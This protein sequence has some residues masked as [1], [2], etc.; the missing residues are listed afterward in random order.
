MIDK[1][2][3]FIPE[4]YFVKNLKDNT[5]GHIKIAIVR[6][7]TNPIIIRS[8]DSEAT[9]TLRMSDQTEVVEIPPRKL[10]SREKLLGL[11]LCREFGAVH[12]SVRYNIIDGKEKLN[13]VNSALFGDTST[14][15]GDTAG[16][17]SRA[18]YDWAYSIRDVTDITD[19]LQHNALGEDGTMWNEAE[20]KQRQSLFMTEYVLPET[21]FP[22]FVTIDNTSPE[23]FLHLLFCILN[24]HRY[25]A[26]TTTNAN[27]MNNYI[28]AIGFDNFE[29]PINSYLISKNWHAEKDSEELN[30][31]SVYSFVQD[32]MKDV[33]GE[34]NLVK[35]LQGFLSLVLNLWKEED[36]KTL[37]SIYSSAIQ[38]VDNFMKDIKMVKK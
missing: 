27:N 23:L 5:I 3:H 8:T 20:G 38:Q 25:G 17:T 16:L 4:K 1:I 35:D 30:L 28:V 11:Q 2:K 12:D 31:K 7:V 21:Y 33:Y 14:K 32:K 15:S 6:E 13:N 37:Q 36:R 34:A 19:K 9:V 24:Q 18:I 29:K 26:Q 10:K 22:H